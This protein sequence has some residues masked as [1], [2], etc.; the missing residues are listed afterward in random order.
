[1]QGVTLTF[2][3]GFDPFN[4]PAEEVQRAVQDLWIEAANRELAEAVADA[5]PEDYATLTPEDL[6]PTEHDINIEPIGIEAI[7]EA[8]A[9]DSAVEALTDVEDCPQC[10]GY[11]VLLDKEVKKSNGYFPPPTCPKCKGAGK[12]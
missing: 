1:M 6:P 4:L 12:C 10:A 11:G 5:V 2:P 8:A 7:A 3:L 9:E